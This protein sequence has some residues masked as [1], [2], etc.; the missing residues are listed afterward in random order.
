M[1]QTDGSGR[2]RSSAQR[3]LLLFILKLYLLL[4]RRRRAF[5]YYL[6]CVM[7]H[8]FQVKHLN[9]VLLPSLSV[10][11]TSDVG[12]GNQQ[13]HISYFSFLKKGSF[14]DI[15]SKKKSKEINFSVTLY[16]SRKVCGNNRATDMKLLRNYPQIAQKFAQNIFKITL[17]LLIDD[18]L[19]VYY[20]HLIKSW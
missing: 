11:Q 4:K 10:C 9:T 19:L 8:Y 17:T 14:M 3:V 16:R 2:N 5:T 13:R 12:G 18:T 20:K 7:C 6:C 15:N 1:I